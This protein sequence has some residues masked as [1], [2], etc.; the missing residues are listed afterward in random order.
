MAENLSELHVVGATF[1]GQ[2]WHTLRKEDGSWTS[3]T[4]VPLISSV[5]K[6]VDIDCVRR[7]SY[8]GETFSEGLWVLVAYEQSPPRLFFRSDT[9]QFSGPVPSNVLPLPT[10]KRVAI[11]VSPGVVPE[12]EPTA[13]S[14]RSYLHLAVV[15]D[16]I[17]PNSLGRVIAAVMPNRGAGT[18]ASGTAEVQ[19]SGAGDLGQASAVALASANVSPFGQPGLES[20]AQLAVALEEQGELFFTYGGVSPSSGTGQ[21]V[22]FRARD[23]APPDGPGARPGRVVDVAFDQRSPGTAGPEH[24]AIVRGGGDADVYATTVSNGVNQST[25]WT[26][27][28]NL[29]LFRFLG[30]VLDADPGN[31]QRVSVA[32][33]LEGYHVVGVMQQSNNGNLMHAL[34]TT[35]EPESVIFR[36]VELV[37]VGQDVGLFVA[38][39]CA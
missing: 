31:F 18:F 29:E 7:I 22:P 10:A 2:V 23:L 32:E 28:R 14:P 25:V 19:T 24:I 35:D 9:G 36:D 39:S 26:P 3:F 33:T 12:G 21:W 27:W 8:P 1:E 5:G 4:E 34:R 30:L 11:T 17:P 20:Q 6:V 37:G 16:G 15:A 38:A 13:G